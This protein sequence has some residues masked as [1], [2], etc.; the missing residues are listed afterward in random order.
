MVGVGIGRAVSQ[1]NSSDAHRSH[2]SRW[3]HVESQIM[4][5]ILRGDAR[6]GTLI[7]ELELSRQFGVATASIREFLIRFSRFGLIEKRPN[8]GGLFKGF[9]TDL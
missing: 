6:P 2:V 3:Q 7:N 5:W 4:D 8:S 9:T 1:S